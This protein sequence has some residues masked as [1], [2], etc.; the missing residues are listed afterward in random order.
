MP[1]TA[2]R[3]QIGKAKVGSPIQLVKDSPGGK[4][5]TSGQSDPS[6]L[7]ESQVRKD[8]VGSGKD[9]LRM[10][11]PPTPPA[12]ENKLYRR[13]VYGRSSRSPF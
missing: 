7:V 8:V 5:H 1:D 10:A 4:S 11:T 2:D 9:S 6:E 3:S 13:F 12:T